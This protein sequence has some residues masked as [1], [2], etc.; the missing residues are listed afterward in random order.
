ME[1]DAPLERPRIQLD[2][3]LNWTFLRKKAGRSW[4][5]GQGSDV[6]DETVCLPHC[7]NTQDTF[8]PGTKHYQGFGS[9]RKSFR[10]DPSLWLPETRWI[11]Q[12]DSFY[13]LG[14]LWLDGS[15]LGDVEGQFLGFSL[16]LTEHLDAG[17]QH[18]L[19]RRLD[20]RARRGVLPGHRMPDF[21][22]YGGLTGG[23]WLLRQ[24][25]LHIPRERIQV[26]CPNALEEIPRVHLSCG[27]FNGSSR[28]RAPRLHCAVRD[29]SGRIVIQREMPVDPIDPGRLSTWTDTVRIEEPK[30]W[31]VDSP[32]LYSLDLSLWEGSQLVDRVDQT[33]G[34]RQ[35]EF[36]EGQGFFLNG[37]RLLLRGCNRHES[38]PGLGSAL[39]PALH[40]MDAELMKS[41]GFNLVRLSHYPQSRAFM[42]A[43]D[44][45][46]LLVYSEV[47]SW[48]SVRTGR[49]LRAAMRQMR[50]MIERDRNRPC[51]LLWGMGNESRSWKAYRALQEFLQDLDPSRPTTYAEHNLAKGERADTLNIPDLLSV[52]YDVK[53][54]DEAVG[55]SRAGCIL[56]AELANFP[57]AARGHLDLELVQVSWLEE[58]LRHILHEPAVAGYALWLFADYATER[59][60]RNYRYS[61]VVDAWRL[62]KMSA[63]WHATISRKDPFLKL[64]GD[65]AVRE[66]REPRPVFVFTNCDR[67]DFYRDDVLLSSAEAPV[68]FLH[69][70]PFE[71]FD[72]VAKGI[73]DG[74]SVE[75][76]LIPFGEAQKVLLSP[77]PL[78]SPS[79][80]LETICLDLLI[81]DERGRQ[82]TDWA[83]TAAVHIVGGAR[84]NTCLEA[85]AFPVAGGI[86]RTFLTGKGEAGT[87]VVRGSAEGLLPDEIRLELEGSELSPHPPL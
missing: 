65:W 47:A 32:Q 13:G 14:D 48:K 55:H 1:Q 6:K 86:G 30:L 15:K 38:I 35:A 58:Y 22:L 59:K 57:H 54:L 78:A 56:L 60:N 67:V 20:N 50:G 3:N 31:S 27:V 36:R 87:V 85:G 61:G 7:W 49:W 69:E 17:K 53:H 74:V 72:L 82:V 51:V 34:L 62:P 46:G 24:P 44:E 11:L 71:P 12:A 40:R 4:L 10:I 66:D 76:R 19:A 28:Q 42:D 9:Y 23:L 18:L 52:N 33:F 73:K 63:A 84:G 80:G 81:A 43:C 8:F 26:S 39:T 45:M 16:D 37:Q 5:S 83:G 29:P 25:R 21:I 70:I 2:F 64:H 79:R 77:K 75:S 41:L 68:P